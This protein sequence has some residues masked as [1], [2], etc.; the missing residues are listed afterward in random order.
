MYTGVLLACIHVHQ[1]GGWK[2]V[3]G[4]LELGLQGQSVLLAIGPLSSLTACFLSQS[5]IGFANSASLVVQ[6]ALG[7]F[8]LHLSSAGLQHTL[9]WVFT[10]LLALK[11]QVLV[12]VQ[13][14]LH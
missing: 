6:Q 13:R 5:S 8:C 3:L 12:L 7:S 1:C 11:P 14:A 2:R 10:W 9:C 4:P